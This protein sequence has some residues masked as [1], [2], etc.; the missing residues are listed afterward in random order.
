M[1][2]IYIAGPYR[3]ATQWGVEQNIRTAEAAMLQVATMGLV[4]LCP[5]TMT[6]YMDGTLTDD[7]WLMATMEMMRRCDGVL[8]CGD[9]E[10]SSGT[11]GECREAHFC[12]IPIYDSI[13]E[14]AA[15]MDVNVL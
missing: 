8:L 4:P 3:A 11:L 9:W 12:E 6:R 7:Y 14:L 1:R 10:Q 13:A 15:S 5:H 2:V